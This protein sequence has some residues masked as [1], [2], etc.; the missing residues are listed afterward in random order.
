MASTIRGQREA[1]ATAFESRTR[2]LR[3]CLAVRDRLVPQWVADVAE[4][5]SRTESVEFTVAVVGEAPSL[6]PRDHRRRTGPLWDLYRTLDLRLQRLMCGDSPD[7]RAVA[8]LGR[9]GVGIADG[10]PPDTALVVNVAGP[11]AVTRL[12]AE[13]GAAHVWW[14]DHDGHELWPAFESGYADVLAGRATRCR[15]LGV[16]TGAPEPV[17]LRSARLATHPL[18]GAENRVQLLWKAIP[19]LLQKVRELRD[20]GAVAWESASESPEPHRPP[21]IDGD[22]EPL[23]LALARHA[24]RSARFVLRRLLWNEQWLL[25][26]GEQ[27][28]TPTSVFQPDRALIPATDRYW[29]DPHFLPR[30]EDRLILVEE[31]LHAERRGRIALLRL[32]DSQEV[33]EV[34]TVLETGY[35]L[36]Y[37]S[38]FELAG[39]LY[40]VPESSEV[41]KVD[42]YRCTSYPWRWEYAGTLLTDVRACD[43][44]IVLHDDR[45]WMFATVSSEPWLTPRDSLNVYYAED[46]LRGP[47]QSHPANPVVCDAYGA[48]PAGQPFVHEGRLY[49]PSQDCSRG[50]GY[51]IRL[52]EVTTLSESRF[53]EREVTFVG[54]SWGET[55]AT[56]T[57]ARGDDTTAVDA[58]RWVRRNRG[59]RTWSALGARA[60][61][62]DDRPT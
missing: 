17:I 5:L 41:A 44:S 18:F 15:L 31:Y 36:S 49:R 27:R 56:H 42:A 7:P 13:C 57:F 34:R 8:D 62:S 1:A 39:D 30:G 28:G 53:E 48:R 40:M 47:W 58:M 2:G 50:Y 55:V 26:L 29:A 52:N 21:P 22:D 4:A 23:V 6:T 12:A 51:G 54:P 25:L 14:F 20:S 9:L 38:V 61:R 46:P 59:L 16:A 3:V 43:C 10:V 35:H 60:R 32:G 33:A 24:W 37:P 45:W 11:G 19:L